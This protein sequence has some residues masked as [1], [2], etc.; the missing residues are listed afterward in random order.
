LPA[1]NAAIRALSPADPSGPGPAAPV[2]RAVAPAAPRR[3]GQRGDVVAIV[4]SCLAPL[5]LTAWGWRYYSLSFAG[6][7]RHPLHGLLKPSGPVGLG[8]GI[9]GLA[10]FLFMWLYP[11]RKAARWLAWTGPVG[12][13][14]RVHVVAGLAIP[15]IV[16]VHAG[17]RFDG[18]IGLGYLSMFVVSLSGIVGRYLHVHI[19]RSRNGLEMSMEEVGG[20]R[21]ALITNIAAATG[22]VPVEVERRLAVDTR[23]YAGLDPVR[24]LWRMF[25]DDLAR[26]RTLRQLERELARPRSGAAALSRHELRETL[27]LARRE[28]ALSQ[29]VRMLEATRRVFGYWHV[30]HR[31]FA[32]T[33]LVAVLVH[34]VVAVVIGGVGFHPG[35]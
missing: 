7:L 8:L 35:H 10:L 1:S 29:Q 33:A 5:A 14:M 23:S 2:L 12:S 21:R 4:L 13:W 18:L 34:V 25:Q 15:L 32:I 28:L 17:W 3:A 31:P 27:K 22:L 24:T 26:S 19:P 20:E 11:F 16:A 30:A 6:R 9:A